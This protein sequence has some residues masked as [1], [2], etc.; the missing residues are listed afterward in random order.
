MQIDYHYYAI[1]TLCH[2]AGIKDDVSHQIAYSSQHVDDAK[3]NHLLNFKDGGIY[4]QEMSAHKFY[5]IE[6][7]SEKVGYDIFMP[8]HFLPG[9][10]GDTFEERLIC[11]SNSK[12][13]LKMMEDT[14]E[15]IKEPFGVHRLG[16]SLH[17]YGD[18]WS[19]NGFNA[20][21]SKYNEVHKICRYKKVNPNLIMMINNT[22]VLSDLQMIYYKYLESFIQDAIWKIK[23]IISPIVPSVGHGQGLTCP[24][25]PFLN[26]QY[27]TY[28]HRKVQNSNIEK[29]M[30]S[31]KHIYDFLRGDLYMADKSLFEGDYKKWEDI[32]PL[33]RALFS[34][35]ASSCDREQNWI[36][37]LKHG[38]FGFKS[39]RVYKDREWFNK[40]ITVVIKEDEKEEYIKSFDFYQSDWKLFQDALKYHK[41]YVRNELIPEL[42]QVL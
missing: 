31:L 39:T 40:A 1:Y 7:L 26:W 13:S 11:L 17:I 23:K 2:L 41:E 38:Y 35:E 4:Q 6:A 12:T 5:K 14:L 25:E 37:K 24:D 42:N 36:L 27:L 33:F 28:D 29:V 21:K 30:D 18:T 32:E 34:F 8:F 20:L 3:Y 22:K 15:T 10:V 9:N 19:H 16:V